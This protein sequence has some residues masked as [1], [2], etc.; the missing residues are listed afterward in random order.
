MRQVGLQAG[1]YNLRFGIAQPAIEFKRLGAVAREHHTEIEYAAIRAAL[2]GERVGYRLHNALANQRLYFG[3]PMPRRGWAVAA[4]AARVR[5][6]VAVAHS[7]VVAGGYHRRHIAAV[8]ECE[9]AD[10][11]PLQA[12]FHY[13][14]I[15]RI[16]ELPL[17][18]SR[19]QGGKR[20]ILCVGDGYALARRQPVRL[21]HKWRCGAF[22]IAA[23]RVVVGERL[24]RGG[25]DAVVSHKPLGECLAAL[26]A[27]GGLCGP[28]YGRAR[29]LKAIHDAQ[30]K[31]R[32]G[33]NH[34][35]VHAVLQR[36]SQ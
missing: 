27:R 33:P 16:P 26:D 23:R 1:Q 13:H 22:H 9:H 28:K 25:G 3:V 10:L 35:K 24:K 8:H 6:G 2:R 19:M 14:A 29:L 12:L 5:P 4:H 20:L 30:R 11:L 15:A 17:H 34:A 18:H 7:L 36:E 21:Y 31:R 32:L